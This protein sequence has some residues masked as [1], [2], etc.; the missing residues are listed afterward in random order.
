MISNR[1][2]KGFTLVELTLSM[3]FIAILLLAISMLIIQMSGIYNKGLTLREANEAGQF[4]SS[5]IQRTLNQTYSAA[6]NI[7]AVSFENNGTGGRLCAGTTVYAW[8]YPKQTNNFELTDGSIINR[9]ANNSSEVR[10][11]K[12]TGTAKE[13]CEQL[14][15]GGWKQIPAGANELLS[16]GNANIAIHGFTARVS[17]VDQDPTQAIY[18][19]AIIVGTTGTG[20]LSD[21]STRCRADN[22]KA[23]QWCAVNEFAFTARAGNKEGS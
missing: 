20:L 17:E 19:V 4:I 6:V 22:Q 13:Y 2:H 3:S 12:F 7:D 1:N 10:F 23:D 15:E 5:E 21:N 18:S 8:N 16:G 14:G 9:A 11:V